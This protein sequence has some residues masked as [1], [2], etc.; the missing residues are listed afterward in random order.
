MYQNHRRYNKNR[1]SEQLM[2]NTLSKD[3]I[4]PS[5]YP[6]STVRDLGLYIENPNLSPKSVASPCGLI[7]KS[8]FNDTY[9]IIPRKPNKDIIRISFNDIS[10]SHDRNDKFKNHHLETK[11]WTSVE[12]C[13]IYLAH[14]INWM[15]IAG[16]PTFKKLW[17]KINSDLHKGTYTLEIVNNYDVS[18]FNGK[19][20]FIL[21]TTSNLGGK[22]SFLG[23][24]SLIVAC[25]SI[26][27]GAGILVLDYFGK[28]KGVDIR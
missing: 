1:S 13:K 5:C 16:L 4:K 26:V 27:G 8:K 14:F 24:V 10:W 2:G 18:D 15:N 19:K 28:R 9:S 17:G 11:M 22:M 12:D 25:F 3:D 20:T 6:V 7:A 21:T 23:I